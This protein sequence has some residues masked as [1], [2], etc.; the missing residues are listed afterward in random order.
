V[1]RRSKVFAKF[2]TSDMWGRVYRQLFTKYVSY[3]LRSFKSSSALLLERQLSLTIFYFNV[4]LLLSSLGYSIS[5][6]NLLSSLI[7]LL[8]NCPKYSFSSRA[9]I[10]FSLLRECIY[11]YIYIYICVCVCVCVCVRVCA[12]ACVR[13]CVWAMC[14]YRPVLHGFYF[15]SRSIVYSLSSVW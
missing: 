7:L 14:L 9:L 3:Y 2:R 15:S 13:V 12:C 1:S 4:V 5:A 8:S 10:H 11:I 6:D